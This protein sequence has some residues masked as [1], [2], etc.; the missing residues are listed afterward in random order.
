MLCIQQWY[1]KMSPLIQLLFIVLSKI[2]AKAIT[3]VNCFEIWSR[4]WFSYSAH[5]LWYWKS[6][7][8]HWPD[9]TNWP[10]NSLLFTDTIWGHR[11]LD[12]VMA[13]CLTAPGHY[14]NQCWLISC[15]IHLKATSQDVVKDLI[16]NMC[17]EITLCI[18]YYISQR[19]MS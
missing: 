13:C 9:T 18:N 6:N 19:P 15:G 14:Q 10:V 2:K 8:Q 7:L 17:L 5:Y 3:I 16:R 4:D 12:R 11:S 1:D